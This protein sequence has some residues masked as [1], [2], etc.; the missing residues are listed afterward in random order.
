M[1]RSI[2]RTA[3]LLAS[4]GALAAPVPA[5]SQEL[6]E[7]RICLR[8]CYEAYYVQTFQPDFYQMCRAHCIE[9]YGNGLVAP[10]TP[11]PLA[12]LRYD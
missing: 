1:K 10:E 5:A 12:V 4:F 2:G 9:W 7:L 8:N 3:T 11:T 6:E